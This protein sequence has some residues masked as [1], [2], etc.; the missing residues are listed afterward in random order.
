[1]IEIKCPYLLYLSDARDVLATKT[2]FGVYD[3]RPESCVGQFRLPGCQP[4]LD[5][6]EISISEA[7]GRA[8]TPINRC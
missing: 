2:A 8:Q 5:L 7:A 1:M 4:L 3:R 6:P